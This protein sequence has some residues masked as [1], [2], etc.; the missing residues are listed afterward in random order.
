MDTITL[1]LA[2]I[3]LPGI[4]GARLDAKYA[5]QTKPSQFD[6][7]LNIFVFG[8]SS[9]VVTY[10]IYK[11]LCLDNY[12]DF[13]LS[14]FDLK[15]KDTLVLIISNINIIFIAVIASIFLSISWVAIKNHKFISRFLQY[16]KVTYRYGDEDVW[17][18]L[19]SSNDEPTR[20]INFRD[21][22]LGITY[23][24]YVEVFSEIPDLRELLL[25]D[26]FVYN[27]ETGEELYQMPRLYIAREPKD[28]T[29]EFPVD[30]TY[31]WKNNNE[32]N[33]E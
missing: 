33:K 8:I 27:S 30:E 11:I 14:Q 24:G 3:F 1:I 4:I 19:L 32:N 16:I 17:D 18:Y 10:I 25:K 13:N 21:I 28:I 22:K 12:A 15:N 23:S 20:Y 26:V 29:L 7:V 2:V 5:S 31:N 9:Y 6:M